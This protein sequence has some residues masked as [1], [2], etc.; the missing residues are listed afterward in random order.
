M[1]HWNYRICRKSVRSEHREHP[2]YFYGLYEVYYNSDGSIWAVTENPVGTGC[3]RFEE[4]G[5]TEE[6][7]IEEIRGALDKM[8][9]AT[10]NPIVDLDTIVYAPQE[11][12]DD[13]ED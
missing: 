12:A 8:L 10:C 5:D 4:L 3:D 1:G 7:A 2:I 11:N 6:W 9:K 13:S